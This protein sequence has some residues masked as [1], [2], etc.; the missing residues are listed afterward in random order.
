MEKNYESVYKAV[1]RAYNSTADELF[2]NKKTRK[3]DNA[4][5]RQIVFTILRFGTDLKL[6]EIKK[7]FGK[8]HATVL[9][10]CITVKGYYKVDTVFRRKMQSIIAEIK[11]DSACD[12]QMLVTRLE[13]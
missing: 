12:T 10:S 6:K 9:Y 1:A 8:S 13:N 7:I 3:G 5:Q 2:A 4:L 11:D